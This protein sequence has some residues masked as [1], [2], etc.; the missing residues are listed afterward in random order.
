M[1][2]PGYIYLMASGRNGTTYL[3]VTSDLLKRVWQHRN[4]VIDSFSKKYGCTRLVWY[5]AFDDIQQARQR[6]LQMKKWKRAW[7]VELI[8]R[9]NPQWLDLFDRLSL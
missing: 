1:G 2:K 8:E 5:E 7:K 9:D 6:E 3:G 4:E